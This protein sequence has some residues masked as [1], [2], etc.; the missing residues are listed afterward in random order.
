MSSTLNVALLG[1]PETHALN[2]YH[3]AQ[4]HQQL[5]I[6]YERL[7]QEDPAAYENLMKNKQK[8][9]DEARK[10]VFI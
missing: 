8:V 1:D 7:K 2:I 10:N 5:L 3:T 9:R 4:I 6:L